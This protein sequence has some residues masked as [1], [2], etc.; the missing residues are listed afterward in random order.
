MF[1]VGMRHPLPALLLPFPSIV[2]TCL[3]FNKYHVLLYKSKLLYSVSERWLLFSVPTNPKPVASQN[4]TETDF[5]KQP[6]F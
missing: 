4:K 3:L 6:R 1:I 2:V 5:V